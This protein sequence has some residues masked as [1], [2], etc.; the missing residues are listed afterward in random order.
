MI[1]SEISYRNQ[2][3]HEKKK[4]RNHNGIIEDTSLK[5]HVD[6]LAEDKWL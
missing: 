4:T 3:S 6:L 5:T 1:K 2:F